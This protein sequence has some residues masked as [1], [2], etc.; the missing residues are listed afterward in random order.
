[1]R[2]QN[3]ELADTNDL[4]NVSQVVFPDGK[5]AEKASVMTRALNVRAAPSSDSKIVNYLRSGDEVAVIATMPGWAFVNYRPNRQ[6]SNLT[7]WVNSHYLSGIADDA[8]SASAMAANR[9]DSSRNS[10][11][12]SG[13]AATPKAKAAKPVAQE[14]AV[15][16]NSGNPALVIQTDQTPFAAGEPMP[17]TEQSG[18]HVTNAALE[19]ESV[20]KL[21]DAVCDM[22]D[23][24]EKTPLKAGSCIGVASADAD[25]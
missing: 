1:M 20:I 14:I 19:A 23:Q 2:E 5:G 4:G 6:G 9:S 24:T 10:A 12:T 11:K 3:R 16:D 15:I 25:E 7:G 18:D 13:K 8:E 17:L 22:G 21:I